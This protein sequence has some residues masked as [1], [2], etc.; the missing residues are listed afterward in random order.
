MQ[1]KK[2]AAL[3]KIKDPEVKA[4]VQKCLATASR[5]LPA[6]ELLMD[7]F[8]LCEGDREAIDCLPPLS[9]SRS[10]VDDMDELGITGEDSSFRMGSNSSWKERRPDSEVQGKG[11]GL[12]TSEKH[13]NGSSNSAAGPVGDSEGEDDAHLGRGHSG[14]HKTGKEERPRRSRDFRVKG[15]RRDDDTIF[16]RLRIADPEGK[17]ISEGRFATWCVTFSLTV[18]VPAILCEVSRL[19]EALL[20]FSGHIRNIHFPFD[21]EA[22]TAMSVATEML[23]ELDLSDQDVTTIAEMIDAEILALVPE[24][25]PGVACDETVGAEAEP[26]YDSRRD[27]PLNADGY[28]RARNDFDPLAT[29]SSEGS[30]LDKLPLHRKM[31]SHSPRLGALMVGSPPRVEGT[32]HG[33]F[34]EIT[35][36]PRG[37]D[38]SWRN[39]DASPVFSSDLSD[40]QEGAS[41]VGG[42][43]N[44]PESSTAELPWHMTRFHGGGDVDQ[45]REPCGNTSGAA[46]PAHR[47]EGSSFNE[48]VE[49]RRNAGYGKYTHQTWE[50]VAVGSRLSEVDGH[51][52][53]HEEQERT[54][55]SVEGHSASQSDDGDAVIADREFRLLAQRQEEEMRAMQWR[56]QQALLSL[57]ARIHRKEGSSE[58]FRTLRDSFRS[59]SSESPERISR[60]MVGQR[61]SS[62]PNRKSGINGF[63]PVD[64]GSPSPSEPRGVYKVRNGQVSVDESEESDRLSMKELAVAF[65]E[66]NAGSREGTASQLVGSGI[67]H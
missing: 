16:L 43:H 67:V 13:D 11:K 8:L 12:A 34:E 23:E 47:V 56:H 40:A 60:H 31:R 62:E 27:S 14:T 39:S 48:L 6:R 57:K 50:A 20:S 4:F 32:M 5:R 46:E 61:A 21:V 66:A 25:K 36:H 63:R 45:I 22:D 24:W 54:S 51:A 17:S 30:L 9:R 10:G 1:G 58:D 26:S 28:P 49:S 55:Q 29:I 52:E 33:R 64:M 65:A 38:Q 42:E 18:T 15:K 3:E 37:S 41:D 59:S 44:S 53:P 2:P 7:P 19:N 35:Y